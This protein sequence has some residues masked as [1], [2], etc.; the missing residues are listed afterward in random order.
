MRSHVQLFLC[1]LS[2]TRLSGAWAVQQEHFMMLTTRR[3]PQRLFNAI[4]AN[5]LTALFA[6]G[7]EEGP[8]LLWL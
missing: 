6:L 8:Q 7:Q 4:L 2:E 1:F 3:D 5:G